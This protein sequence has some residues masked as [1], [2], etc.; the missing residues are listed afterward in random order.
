MLPY[1]DYVLSP[2]FDKVKDPDPVRSAK[3]SFN[4]TVA[5]L[6]DLLHSNEWQYF[7]T[8]TLDPK[9]VRDRYDYQCSI[10]CIQHFTDLL[11]RSGSCYVIVP[12]RHEDGAWH[13]HGVLNNVAD[14]QLDVNY[15][16]YFTLRQ[17]HY[18]YS[19][20]SSIVDTAKAANYIL[21]YMVKGYN[22]LDIPKGKKRYFASRSL[23]MPDI[24]NDVLTSQDVDELISK[25][26]WHKRIDSDFYDGYI[27]DIKEST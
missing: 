7:I 15:D 17:Y 25:S 22:Y 2:G 21:K 13:F 26:F 27:I 12:E 16:Q 5:H 1:K 6:Y 23:D 20:V 14:S 3:N 10:D 8:L 24:E 18:G 9:I 11:Y 4:R 19:S